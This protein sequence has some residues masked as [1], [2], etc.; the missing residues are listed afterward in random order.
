MQLKCP[1]FRTVPVIYQSPNPEPYVIGFDYDIWR[2]ETAVSK[3]KGLTIYIMLFKSQTPDIK[4][5]LNFEWARYL[6]E[7]LEDVEKAL[8]IMN[9]TVGMCTFK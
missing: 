7:K 6:L 2:L 1:I 8:R 9:N 5:H 3:V 4:Q